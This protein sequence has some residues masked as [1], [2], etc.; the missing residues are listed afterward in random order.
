VPVITIN[1][2]SITKVYRRRGT[3]IKSKEKHNYVVPKVF[4]EPVHDY[5]PVGQNP[6]GP[7]DII[8]GSPA[9][10]SKRKATPISVMN[11]RRCKR[12]TSSNKGFKHVTPTTSKSRKK[13]PKAPE[14]SQQSKQQLPFFSLLDF[15]DLAEVDKIIASGSKASA[16]LWISSRRWHWKGVESQERWWLLKKEMI[17]TRGRKPCTSRITDGWNALKKLWG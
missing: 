13:L 4:A 15:P 3:K 11:L 2:N 8:C 14:K 12:N 6:E 9:S 10:T 5:E 7:G 1:N 16:F 17:P